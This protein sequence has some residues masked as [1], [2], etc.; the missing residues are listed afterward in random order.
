MRK[1]EE[2]LQ[3]IVEIAKKDSRVLAVG[4]NGSRVNK[5]APRDS[6]QEYDIVYIVKSVEACVKDQSWI[7]EFGSR[8]I[9]QT[10]EERVLFPSKRNGR[11][12]FLMLFDDGNWIDLTLCPKEQAETWNERDRLY[13]ILWDKEQLLPILSVATDQEYWGKRPSQAEFSDCCNEFWWII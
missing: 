6:F 13:Q 10:P 2:M 1:E 8:L 11:F 12:T 5:N 7:D 3:L 9:M 4:M